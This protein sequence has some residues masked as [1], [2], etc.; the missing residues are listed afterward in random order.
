MPFA[1]T[2]PK[3]SPTMTEG[4]IFRWHKKPGDRIEPGDLLLE[5]STDKATVEHSSLDEGYL[6]TILCPDGEKAE[7]N[8]PL[9]ICSETADESIEGFV[10]KGVTQAAIVK[11]AIPQ[12]KPAPTA[13]VQEVR[14]DRV[15]ASPL[16]KKLAKNQGIDLH[17]ISGSGPRGRIMSRDLTQ[18]A[19]KQVV[20]APCQASLPSAT[21]EEALSPMRRVIAKRLQESK[22]LIPHFYVRQELDAG[23]IT[24]MREQLKGLERSFTVN[25]FIIKATALALEMHPEVNCGFNEATQ[26]IIRFAQVDLS[27]AVTVEGGLITPIIK[28]AAKK[29]LKMLS[30][31]T[32]ALAQKARAG[33]LQPDEYIGGSFTL[34]N[35]GM[36]GITEMTPIVNPPQGAILGVG[37]IFDAPMVKNGAIVP[38]KKLVLTLS[39][40]HRIIDGSAAA[41][42]L[43]TLKEL[44]EN[45]LLFLTV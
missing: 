15:I 22:S 34:S 7:V 40:D 19:P 43:K 32:K 3:L 27:I 11:P 24:S 5:I 21:Y 42:F 30:E 10:P 36:Y 44:I 35:L 4:V 37:A 31:E 39:C 2:M 14:T 29:S 16:A 26:K 45:P 13:A 25:D 17:S 6:R 9:A 33:K 41:Q 38:G 18:E 1:I 8:A 23:M 28:N 20:A 12:E